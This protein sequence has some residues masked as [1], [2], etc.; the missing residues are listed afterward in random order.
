MIALMNKVLTIVGVL[1]VVAAGAY[2]IIGREG[3]PVSQASP[4]P[5]VSSSP[6]ASASASPA[7]LTDGTYR[8]VAASSSMQWQSKKSLLKEYVDSGTIGLREGSVV[9]RNGA[10]ASGSLVVDMTTIAASSTGKGTGKDQLSKHLKSAD[11]FDATKYPTATFRLTSFVRQLGDY[12][13]IGDLTVKGITKPV[14]FPATLTVADGSL[15]LSGA[16]KVDR[17]QYDVRFGSGKFFSNL[18]DTVIDDFF[19]VTF[20]AVAQATAAPVASASVAPVP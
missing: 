7:V 4:S 16:A 17:T 5:E 9:I 15:T 18:G 12:L 6:L 13:V 10:V 19:T 8:L 3:T 2:V 14:S 11:F 1:L 20:T